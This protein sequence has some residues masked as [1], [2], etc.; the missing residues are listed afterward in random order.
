M[1]IYWLDAHGSIGPESKQTTVE[2]KKIHDAHCKLR[3]CLRR[4]VGKRG[5]ER[6]L[7]KKAAT[8]AAI[9][10]CESAF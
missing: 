1:E 10:V 6:N 7:K 4:A 2:N 3:Q 9:K 5:R 8:L